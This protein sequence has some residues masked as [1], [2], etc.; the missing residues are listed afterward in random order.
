MKDGQ[1]I[2][3]FYAAIFLII[4]CYMA[5]LPVW[6]KS[7]GFDEGQV[8]LIFAL[9][10]LMRMVFTP[11]I[12]FLADRLG[13]TR[14]MV[15]WLAHGTALSLFSLAG[16]PSHEMIF[17]C[18]VVYALLWTSVVPLTE[19]IA[20]ASARLSGGDYGHMRMW[21]SLTFILAVAFGGF[22]VDIWGPAAGLWLVIVSSVLMAAAAHLLPRTTPPHPSPLLSKEGITVRKALLFARSGP[23]V[24]FLLTATA[25]NA[26]H[27][28]YNSLATLHWLSLDISP[29]VIGLLWATGVIAEIALFGFAGRVVRVLR[30]TTL[31]AIGAA[32]AILRWVVTAFNPPLYILFPI[33]M[34]H[35]L[36]YGA[37]HLGAIYF[38]AAAAPARYAATAQGLYAAVAA[39]LGMGLATIAAGPLYKSL[40]AWAFLAMA[41]LAV[42]SLVFALMLA[43][44]WKGGLLIPAEAD[45]PPAT[46][47]QNVRSGGAIM[48]AE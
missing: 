34:L 44:R 35:S 14:R 46:Q 40:N 18:L 4:G 6:L 31:M 2:A 28:V 37:A 48:P 1:R 10:L 24:L 12:S 7:R 33:Q 5:Y 43:A 13:N 36:T 15:F 23:F 3:L 47:P 17:A 22:A 16:A 42:A 11:F 26:S 29:T 38:L 9:P 27:A 30:P 41:T 8:T 19:T 32:A 20:V 39:G 25:V 45:A 21:G